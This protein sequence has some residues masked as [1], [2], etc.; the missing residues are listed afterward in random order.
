MKKQVEQ[1]D[2]AGSRKG[3]A[4]SLV[5]PLTEIREAPRRSLSQ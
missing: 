2:N 1:S 5:K 4:L 3:P